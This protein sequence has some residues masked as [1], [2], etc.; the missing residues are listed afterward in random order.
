MLCL[1]WKEMHT[2]KCRKLIKAGS[3]PIVTVDY[4]SP[5][6][7]ITPSEIQPLSWEYGINGL[8]K[9]ILNGMQDLNILSLLTPEKTDITWGQPNHIKHIRKCTC[10]Q[11]AQF[12]LIWCIDICSSMD[13]QL[14]DP[15]FGFPWQCSIQRF[16]DS[17]ALN[18]KAGYR[19]GI[20]LSFHTSLGSACSILMHTCLEETASKLLAFSI[21]IGAL[22]LAW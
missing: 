21:G 3:L 22:Q 14:G 9:I 17:G 8:L 16:S 1:E 7:S 10:L 4:S 2:N 15:Y 18:D 19:N 20:M 6:S 5:I 13:S 11:H 12:K